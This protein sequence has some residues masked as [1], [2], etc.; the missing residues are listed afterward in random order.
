[1][2]LPLQQSPAEVAV[3]VA[4][5]V[6]GWVESFVVGAAA[7]AAA[8]AA[9]VVV[10]VVV[11]AVVVVALDDVVTNAAAEF[12]SVTKKT[13]E[14]IQDV[15]NEYFFKHICICQLKKSKLPL[16]LG[17]SCASGQQSEII[18]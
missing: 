16:Q 13:L 2:P 14:V 12:G 4:V 11:A 15:N 7:A 6:V 3:A 1:M 8:A 10:V 17:L 18:I 9:A 5:V